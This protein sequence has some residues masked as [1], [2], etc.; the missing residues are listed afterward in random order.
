M[1]NLSYTAPIKEPAAEIKSSSSLLRTLGLLRDPTSSPTSSSELSKVE[2]LTSTFSA[3]RRTTHTY[4]NSW[5]L[6]RLHRS[7]SWVPKPIFGQTFVRTSLYS[8][9]NTN[10][11]VHSQ[12][13]PKIYKGWRCWECWVIYLL[14][15]QLEKSVKDGGIKSLQILP[16]FFFTKTLIIFSD[17]RNFSHT[18]WLVILLN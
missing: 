1:S 7:R 5:A 2:A 11:E 12:N 18:H 17:I 6:K 15:S 13:P 14:P 9:P 16:L 10:E 3:D 8:Q 4:K